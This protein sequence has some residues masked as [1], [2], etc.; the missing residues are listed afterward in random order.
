MLLLVLVALLAWF[1]Y[2]GSRKPRGFPPGPVRLPLVGYLPNMKSEHIYKQLWQMSST[3]GNIIGLYFGSQATIIVNGWEAVKE[4]ILNDDLDGRPE[5]IF[6]NIFFNDKQ[7]GVMFVENDFWKEQRRFTLHKFRDLGFGKRSHEEVIQE[8]ANELIKE[9][10]ETKGSISLQGMVGVSAINILWALM[11]GTRFSRKDGRLLHLVNILNELFRSGNAAGGIETVFPALRH[12]M[13]D[14]SSFNTAIRNIKPIQEFIKKSV[15]EHKADFDADNPRDFID[16]YITE[17]K[18][19]KFEEDTT[20]TDDQLLAI[21]GDVFSAGVET[22]SSSV[23]FAILLSVLSPHVMGKIQ[24]ELD[25]VVGNV[26]LPS[27]NDRTKL[28]YT[29]AT[30]TE[31][32]RY[33]GSAPLT[34]PHKALRDTKLQG[35]RIPAGTVVMNNLYSVHMDPGYWGDPETFRPERFINPDGSFRKDERVIPFGKGRRSCLGE[36]LARMTTFLLFSSLMQHFTFSLDP[37]I[38]VTN[39]D[40]KMG[41]TLAPPD[42]RVFAKARL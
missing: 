4:S 36:S 38:P 31:V 24:Q 25:N 10:K 23:S 15:A 7:R 29:D 28:V 42:F 9:I 34:V 17:L 22:G 41:F 26:R 16:I 33:R 11:G 2:L 5:N 39:T 20:F 18:K 8:E 13:P 3:Y 37:A 12:I 21:C 27:M 40:G 1:L 19:R 30:Q 14:S 35:F 32:F 6:S